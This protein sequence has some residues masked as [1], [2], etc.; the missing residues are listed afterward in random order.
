MALQSGFQFVIDAS[1]LPIVGQVECLEVANTS[2][3]GSEVPN[4]DHL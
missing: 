4:V 3:T 2:K 1:I